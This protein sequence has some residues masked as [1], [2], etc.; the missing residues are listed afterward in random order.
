MWR[1]RRSLGVLVSVVVIAMVVGFGQARAQYC[2]WQDAQ[3]HFQFCE[4]VY[5]TCPPAGG[6]CVRTGCQVTIQELANGCVFGS[7]YRCNLFGCFFA[8]WD[9][10]AC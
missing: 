4:P 6:T 5:W 9:C 8:Q 3:A 7:A 2:N 1:I 10:S